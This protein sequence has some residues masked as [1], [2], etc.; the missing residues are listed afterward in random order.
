MTRFLVIGTV[1]EL[2]DGEMS[3][4]FNIEEAYDSIDDA[5]VAARNRLGD[6]S[7]NIGNGFS[8]EIKGEIILEYGKAVV[9]RIY[10]SFYELKYYIQKEII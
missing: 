4:N 1:A 6:I 2:M 5:I 3:T 9:G 10:N 8:V 7:E